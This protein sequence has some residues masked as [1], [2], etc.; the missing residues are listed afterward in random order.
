MR[1]LPSSPRRR[2]RLA[3]TAFVAFVAL[4]IGVTFAVVHGPRKEKPQASAEAGPI[5]RPEQPIRVTRELRAEINRTLDRFVPAAVLRR[6]PMAAYKL[7]TPELQAAASRSEWERGEIPVYPF[8]VQGARFHGWTLNY[9]ITD[10]VNV[11]LMLQ[12]PPRKGNTAGIAYTVDLK[13]ID[14]KWLVNSFF[15]T[16][17]FRR[18]PT[19]S[20]TRIVAQ[21]DLAPQQVEGSAHTGKGEE[22]IERLFVL[23]PI[24]V[25]GLGLVL[26]VGVFVVQGIR[27]RRAQR[28]YEAGRPV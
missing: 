4:A 3:R 11:D 23:A 24:A 18:S 17:E 8:E 5:Q 12:A 9:A 25:V 27:S 22:R 7:S 2:R 14:G 13:R 15:P 1:L 10:N 20:G 6:D 28:A 26:V 16:A 19:Q 21:P